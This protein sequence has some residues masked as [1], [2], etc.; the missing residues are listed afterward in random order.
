[1]KRNILIGS[2]N[3]VVNIGLSKIIIVI[4]LSLYELFFIFPI[5]KN[6]LIILKIYIYKR[7][8]HHILVEVDISGINSIGGPGSYIKGINQVLPFIWRNCSFISSSFNKKYFQ[9]DLYLF[10][11]PNFKKKQ[12]LKFIK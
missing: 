1:M 5:L 4:I 3:I 6:E 11:I 12:Y 7:F 2:N 10:T 9:K 8:F